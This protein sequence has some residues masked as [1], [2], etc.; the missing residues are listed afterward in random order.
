LPFLVPFSRSFLPL[1]EDL[2]LISTL[3]QIAFRYQNWHAGVRL[4]LTKSA[5]AKSSKFAQI[6]SA[7]TAPAQCSFAN[8]FVVF[9]PIFTQFSSSSRRRYADFNAV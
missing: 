7:Q 5:R 6:C 3:Y 8:N 1:P 2:S 4:E 9:S